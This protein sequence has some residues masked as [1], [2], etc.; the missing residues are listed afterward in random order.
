MDPLIA[1]GGSQYSV[2]WV[3][4]TAMDEVQQGERFPIRYALGNNQPNT[5][6][7]LYYDADTTPANGHELI[8]DQATD[9]PSSEAYTPTAAGRFQVFLPEMNKKYYSGL[10][11]CAGN[12][13]LWNT[14]QIPKGEYYVCAEASD[15]LNTN[16]RCSESPIAIR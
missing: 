16:Y 12:C 7:K 2:D 1:I 9:A 11:P 13:Y 5:N 6:I 3:K 8:W 14:T 4:L 15:S 10:E